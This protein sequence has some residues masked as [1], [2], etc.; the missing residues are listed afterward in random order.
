MRPSTTNIFNATQSYQANLLL[1]CFIKLKR[2][3]SPNK[4]KG[5]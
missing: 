3:T 2:A 5:S 1:A 4:K